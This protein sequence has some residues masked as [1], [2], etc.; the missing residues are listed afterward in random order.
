VITQLTDVTLRSLELSIL[1]NPAKRIET[2]VA[3][4]LA[5]GPRAIWE[6][7]A[8]FSCGPR[9]ILMSVGDIEEVVDG[10]LA[11]LLRAVVES[12]GSCAPALPGATRTA[13]ETKVLA[14]SMDLSLLEGCPATADVGFR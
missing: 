12:I 3:S 6:A 11:P 13:A 10:G 2:P 14:T 1:N 8:T 5:A 7:L 9:V 4:K